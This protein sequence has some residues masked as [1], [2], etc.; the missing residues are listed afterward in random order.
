[1][2]NLLVKPIHQGFG[3]EV[4]GVDFSQ[5]VSAKVVE[6]LKQIQ[7]EYAFTI[8]RSTQLD[9]DRHVAF[10]S[11]LGRQLE[12][13]P[14]YAISVR[15][16]TPY[17][18]DVGNIEPDGSLVEKD[19]RRWQ[20]ALGN[21][22]WH[23]DSSYSSPRAKYSLLCCYDGARPGIANTVFADTRNAY[24][25]LDA[26]TKA[27]IE[28]L[29]V[30]HDLWH[31]RKI[32]SPVMYANPTSEEKAAKPPSCHKLV[33]RGPDGRKTLYIAAH[34]KR[35]VGMSEEAGAKLIGDLLAHSTKPKYTVEVQWR[36]KGDMIWWDNRISMH[37]AT[38]FAG[39]FARDVRRATV[40]DD[41]PNSFG[42]TEHIA[43]RNAQIGNISL[44]PVRQQQ[45]LVYSTSTTA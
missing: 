34:A 23:T 11:Q 27:F 35:V 36:N 26:E 9:N 16:G 15:L 22:L 4:E 18:F 40:V 6:Q 20:H 3:A 41:G 42:V 30:E 33:Q 7:N 29:V 25:D 28:D 13:N 32:A 39:D 19:S 1:M 12:K 45:Q 44:S 38:P 37:R 8:Y 21:A 24:E 17:L 10:A 5:P 31:S 14:F 43:V 2:E